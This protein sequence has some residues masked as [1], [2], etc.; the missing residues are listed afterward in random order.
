MKAAAAHALNVA[1][2]PEYFVNG[3]QVKTFGY[4]ELGSLIGEELARAS[5]DWA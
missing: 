3:R 4:D 2:T 1:K 5:T